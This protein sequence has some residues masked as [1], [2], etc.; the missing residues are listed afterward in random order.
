MPRI[1]GSH[2]CLAS[3]ARIGGSHR[4]HASVARALILKRLAGK[5]WAVI[6]C[7]AARQC[8]VSQCP[9]VA[10]RPLD[11]RRSWLHVAAAWRDRAF[12][13]SSLSVARLGPLRR[14]LKCLYLHRHVLGRVQPC[15]GR[16]GAWLDRKRVSRK[17]T[18]ARQQDTPVLI[19]TACQGLVTCTCSIAPGRVPARC[20]SF[21]FCRRLNHENIAFIATNPPFDVGSATTPCDATSLLVLETVVPAAGARHPFRHLV[22]LP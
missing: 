6:A 12:L 15:S 10:R 11:D 16:G 17:K 8:L 18:D 5:I 4:W 19:P 1:G 14:S 9:S 13:N 3:V 22:C 20:I 7:G 2:R 21:T